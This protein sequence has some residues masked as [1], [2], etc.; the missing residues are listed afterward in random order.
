MTNIDLVI[1]DERS[2]TVFTYKDG[3]VKIRAK[4][5]DGSGVRGYCE[6][7]VRSTAV[8]GISLNKSSYTFDEVGKSAYLYAN[9]MPSNATNKSVTWS[10]SDDSVISVNQFASFRQACGKNRRLVLLYINIQIHK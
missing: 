9:V 5:Q 1:F 6:V 4:A 7:T 3:T 10:S 2:G 8:T